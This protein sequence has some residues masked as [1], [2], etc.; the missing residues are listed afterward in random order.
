MVLTDRLLV[1]QIVCRARDWEK[2]FAQVSNAL[3]VAL[4]GDRNLEIVCH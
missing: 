4:T 2:K 3:G 1:T